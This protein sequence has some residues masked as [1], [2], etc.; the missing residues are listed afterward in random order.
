MSLFY[1]THSV[2]TVDGGTCD[3][4]P[5]LLKLLI[6]NILPFRKPY[7]EDPEFRF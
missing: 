6:K 3:E 1:S 7:A 4:R 5:L 2:V